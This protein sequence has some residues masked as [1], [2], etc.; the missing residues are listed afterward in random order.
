MPNILRM[1][2]PSKHHRAILAIPA[3]ALVG[4]EGR[5]VLR[6]G[7][8]TG[9]YWSPYPVLCASDG[10]CADFPPGTTLRFTMKACTVRGRPAARVCG[11][12]CTNAVS[13]DCECACEGANH[14]LA[15]RGPA[16]LSRR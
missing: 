7:R 6:T 16:A 11:P 13:L 8:E 9:G 15:F 5:I 12:A 10:P 1:R 4:P 14:G 2:C 3:D